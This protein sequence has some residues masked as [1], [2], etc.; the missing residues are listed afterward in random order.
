MEQDFLEL[1]KT[2]K[3]LIKLRLRNIFKEEN[4]EKDLK[5]LEKILN[6]KR[7]EILELVDKIIIAI[8]SHTKYS[9]FFI[10]KYSEI[11]KDK[12]KV[13]NKVSVWDFIKV[14]GESRNNDLSLER[15][16]VNKGLVDIGEIKE[17]YRYELAR[18]EIKKL[19]ESAKRVE[20]PESEEVKEV[21]EYIDELLKDSFKSVEGVKIEASF[22]GEVPIEWHPP[23]IRN[24]LNDILSG[25]SP[26]HYARRSFVVYWFAAKFNPN[27][28]PLK[29]GKLVELSA[30]DITSEKNIEEFIE[31]VINIFKNVE[32]FD[33]EK[34]RYYIM[35]NIGYKV[36]HQRFTHCEY[37]RNWQ[38]DNGKGLAQYCTPDEIC[39]KKFIIHPLDYLCYMIKTRGKHK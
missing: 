33:E 28:R 35:H 34:T 31:E 1:V 38:N 10:K 16:E 27:L 14:S 39:K 4:I 9:N 6:L 19:V 15:V 29:D 8:I 24:I 20:L 30:R 23:C 21:I 2:Y 12:I 36:G 5:E 18:L 7:E 13:P 11:L 37:C 22:K 17:I 32:D 25:G 3:F 26:S